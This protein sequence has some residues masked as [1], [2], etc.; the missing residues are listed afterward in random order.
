V[1]DDLMGSKII[2]SSVNSNYSLRYLVPS[3]VF[4]IPGLLSPTPLKVQDTQ[5]I[6][7]GFEVDSGFLP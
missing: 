3:C 1:V 5:P 4:Y 7:M 2:N 6:G